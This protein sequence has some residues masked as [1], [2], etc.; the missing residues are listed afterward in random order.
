MV[1]D[2]KYLDFY[3]NG[4]KSLQFYNSFQ[5]NV[6]ILCKLG[7]F[8]VKM[9]FSGKCMHFDENA[10]ILTENAQKQVFWDRV[11]SK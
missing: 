3:W 11:S 4:M 9:K 8:S 2:P 6:C 1:I 5:E 10:R 7:A